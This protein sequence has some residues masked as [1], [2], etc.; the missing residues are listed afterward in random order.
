MVPL[1]EPANSNPPKGQ[2]PAPQ[3]KKSMVLSKM[4]VE[5]S[6]TDIYNYYIRVYDQ[7]SKEYS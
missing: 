3:I 1:Q 4:E 7:P 5:R 6:L 2:P